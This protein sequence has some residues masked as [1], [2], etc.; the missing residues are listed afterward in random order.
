MNPAK[1]VL[2]LE[3]FTTEAKN[4]VRRFLAEGRRI[5]AIAYLC[6]T[7]NLTAEQA[8]QLVQIVERDLP[9]QPQTETISQAE[10]L[11]RV[12][13]EVPSAPSNQVSTRLKSEVIELIQTKKKLQAIKLVRQELNLSL[14]DA[15]IIVDDIHKEVDPNFQPLKLDGGC[16]RVVFKVIAYIFLA[17]TIFSLA[18]GAIIYFM[19]EDTVSNGEKVSG[20]VTGFTSNDTGGSAPI[21]EYNWHGEKREYKST[22]F[23]TPPSFAVNEKVELYINKENPDDALIDSFSERWLVIT[24]FAGIAAFFALFALA[25]LFVSRKF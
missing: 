18:I 8:E 5:T 22:L 16:V 24:V 10:T 1:I 6:N 9:E 12:E 13:Y 2:P 17:V 21:V 3:H 25:L 7:F 11:P 23:S 15:A 19:Q 20:V 14:K 4:E